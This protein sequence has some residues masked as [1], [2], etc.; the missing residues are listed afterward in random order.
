MLREAGDPPAAAAIKNGDDMEAK[1]LVIELESVDSTNS[2]IR[3]HPGLWERQFCAVIAREQ[4]AG[5]GRHGRRWHS[6]PGRD[7]TFSL[8]FIPPAP[9]PELSC[10]TVIA[11]LA[12]YRTLLPRL[13]EGLRLKW[14]NDIIHGGKKIGGILCEM[15]ETGERPA[16]IIGIGINV[17]SV[18]FPDGLDAAT[19]LKIATGEKQDIRALFNEILASL[20]GLL[21]EFSGPLDGRIRGEWEAASLSIGARVR[22]AGPKGMRGGVAIG[23][24]HDGSLLIRDDEEG[25]VAACGGEALFEDDE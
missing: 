23:I 11:G 15:F 13:G 18:G 19:S 24:N 20:T 5:R 7:L 1:R 14:P 17:N 8:L 25:V 9:F 3:D 2:Y 16:V 6:A 10:V 4:R 12:A 22:Y 21:S